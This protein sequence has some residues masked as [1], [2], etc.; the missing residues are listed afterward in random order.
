MVELNQQ[1]TRVPVPP[2]SGEKRNKDAN[3]KK[4]KGKIVDP[5][6]VSCLKD[7]LDSK[8]QTANRRADEERRRQEEEQRYV[9][10]NCSRMTTCG[11]EYGDIWLQI[12]D[13]TC[14]V[15]LKE[16]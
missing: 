4:I 5:V 6:D 7:D 9:A 2:T 1:L 13:S 15:F 16:S 14:A 11:L 3:R 8:L 10:T 12:V